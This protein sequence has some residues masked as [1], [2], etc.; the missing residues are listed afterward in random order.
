MTT[1]VTRQDLWNAL[2]R[3]YPGARNSIYFR[4]FNVNVG[5]DVHAGDAL[6][7]VER[8]RI[9]GNINIPE[10]RGREIPDYILEIA[11]AGGEVAIRGVR[12]MEQE[13]RYQF[14]VEEGND[15]V[16]SQAENE[17]MNA[18]G[19]LLPHPTRPPARIRVRV[20]YTAGNY[21]PWNV[22][23]KIGGEV[24]DF[25]ALA[26]IKSLLPPA[27]KRWITRRTRGGTLR[28][29]Q[30]ALEAGLPAQSLHDALKAWAIATCS[31]IRD[32]S[33]DSPALGGVDAATESLLR[34]QPATLEVAG[35][36]FRL[37]PVGEVDMRPLI[38]R[39]RARALSTVTIE[40]GAIRERARAD[41]RTVISEAERRAAAIR[42]ELDAERQRH[43]SRVPDWVRDSGRPHFWTGHEWAVEMMVGIKVREIRYTV[44]PWNVVLKWN[45]LN[46]N[47][48]S[49]D[50]YAESRNMLA[51]WVRIREEGTYQFDD[52]FTRD[53]STTHIMVG[54][55][56]SAYTCCMGLQARPACIRS[57]AD[58]RT[59]E[60]ALTRGMQVIN[61]NSPL[62]GSVSNYHPTFLEQIPPIP[63]EVLTND[64]R[65]VDGNG[66]CL[67]G[68][69]TPDAYRVVFPNVTWD[70]ME[71]LLSEAETTF[72]VTEPVPAPVPVPVP[73]VNQGR[74]ERG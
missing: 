64:V 20:W 58:L 43:G 35:R 61:M 68:A 28:G 29:L 9:L 13:V 6:T 72:T 14:L 53:Y 40:A 23:V 31:A 39:T 56:N 48:R 37:T 47:R 24:K 50:W 69:A 65:F 10:R 54:G 21:N 1:T 33:S 49:N 18:L 15:R 57:V 73:V 63:R 16:W 25:P 41:S 60:V 5:D 55:N 70:S 42:L 44:T 67:P 7:P 62:S 17:E 46:P 8:G 71:S 45:P 32:A 34:A 30:E 19:I 27:D 66:R 3:A 26:V 22:Q 51:V 11:S 74:G 2:N 36:V 4:I 59:L 52:S 38:A 12:T